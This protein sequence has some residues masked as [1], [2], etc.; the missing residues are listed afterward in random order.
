MGRHM[1]Y[2]DYHASKH[3][4][5]KTTFDVINSKPIAHFV[6]CIEQTGLVFFI[7]FWYFDH[8]FSSNR[9]VAY[10]LYFPF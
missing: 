10:S 9:G 6:H 1:G 7:L 3:I 5:S 4:E 8:I 2:E